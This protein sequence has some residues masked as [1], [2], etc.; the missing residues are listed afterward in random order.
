MMNYKKKL[1]IYYKKVLKSKIM[2]VEIFTH[3]QT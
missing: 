2:Y 1:N 3:I